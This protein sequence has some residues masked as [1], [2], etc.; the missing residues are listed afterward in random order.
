M[1]RPNERKFLEES[2]RHYTKA[3]LTLILFTGRVKHLSDGSDL[4]EI[5]DE[6]DKTNIALNEFF[7][8]MVFGNNPQPEGKE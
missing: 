2:H 3:E 5:A 4:K 7:Q 6:L 8:S 1:L